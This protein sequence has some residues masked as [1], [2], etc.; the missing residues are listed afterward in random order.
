[1]Q[2]DPYLEDT[3]CSLCG[4]KQGPYFCRDLGC[5]NYFC[6]GCW[7]LQHTGRPHHK[8][9]MRNIRGLTRARASQDYNNNSGG[10]YRADQ[11]RELAEQWQLLSL[12]QPGSNNH[13]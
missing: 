11:M 8:P 10:R 2:V 13:H 3:L 12:Q 5:F 6:H 9:L 7:D 1:M 4:L